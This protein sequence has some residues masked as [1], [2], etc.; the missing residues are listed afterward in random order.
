M[1][2]EE[3]LGGAAA[4]NDELLVLTA[5]NRAAIRGLPEALGPRF[6]DFGIC[7]QTMV[8]AAAELALRGRVPVVH[9]LAA[10]LTMRAFEFVRTDVGIPALAVKLVG[11]VPGF[12]SEANG[13]THQAVEDVALM[14]GIPAMKVFC[15]ADAD[16]LV[17]GM[18][19]VI[20]DP[21]PWYVR[22]NAATPAAPGRAP[23]PLGKAEIMA[24]GEDAAILTYGLLAGEAVRASR[25]LASRGISVRVISLRTL[26][27][28]DEEAV[29]ASARETSLVVTLEDHFL[30]GGLASI[31]AELFLER[32]L[33][34]RVLTLG[35]RDR[36]FTPALLPEVLAAEGFTAGQ[37]ADRIQHELH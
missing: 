16:D 23:P 31:A 19:E 28:L 9:A 34:P 2:Y 20:A 13:P 33:S 35:L 21:A 7:E 26:K 3:M 37:I 6:L 10:F 30:T 22:F 29:L 18:P 12:L 1:T 27:P 36:W 25:L 15:P 5:E 8:G 14:R 17:S 11:G 32:R 24:G 4:R